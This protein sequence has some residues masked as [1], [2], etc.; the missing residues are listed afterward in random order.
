MFFI[1]WIK[2]SLQLS[3]IPI[4]N[5][6]YRLNVKYL[7]YNILS[8]KIGKVPAYHLNDIAVYKEKMYTASSRSSHYFGNSSGRGETRTLNQWLKR[9]LLC[10]WATRPKRAALYPNFLLLLCSLYSRFSG[11]ARVVTPLPLMS[12][13]ELLICIISISLLGLK[14]HK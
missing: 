4:W 13:Q 6:K 12:A 3:S 2:C 7:T 14:Y 10:H 9:P 5:N 8:K 1:Y 11:R